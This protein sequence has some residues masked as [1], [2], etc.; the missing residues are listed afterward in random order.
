MKCL[1]FTLVVMLIAVFGDPAP[2]SYTGTKAPAE[3]VPSL[4]AEELHEWWGRELRFDADTP[5]EQVIARVLLYKLSA[6]TGSS[7]ADDPEGWLHRAQKSADLQ[8]ALSWYR[9]A[10]EAGLPEAQAGLAALHLSGGIVRQDPVRTQMWLIVAAGTVAKDRT[11]D[12]LQ[13]Y[14]HWLRDHV[15]ERLSPEQ[16]AEAERLAQDWAPTRN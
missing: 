14:I 6:E 16:L 1:V 12:D 3:I 5:R 4:P 8:G 2:A 11:R 15:A 7:T 9:K 10:A 13:F